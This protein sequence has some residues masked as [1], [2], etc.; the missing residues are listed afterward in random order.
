MNIFAL[1]S[2]LFTYLSSIGNTIFGGDA[3]GLVSAILTKGFP[4]PPGYPL[5]TM[6]GIIAN[7]LPVSLSPAGKITLI[8]L[9]ST[10]FSLILFTAIIKEIATPQYVHKIILSVA[11]YLIG[12]NY[13][14]W[15]YS[16]VPEVF[17]LNTAITLS[18]FYSA[19]K[20]HKTQRTEYLYFIFFLIGLGIAHHHTFVIVIPSIIYLLY[21]KRKKLHTT[22]KE[23][24]FMALAF[25]IGILPL[26]YLLYHRSEVVWGNTRTLA[27]FITVL[28]RA[29]YGSFTAGHFV[30]NLASHRILQVKNL[31]FFTRNDFTFWG[32]IIA[33]AGLIFYL[34]RKKSETKTLLA[35]V[36]INIF[37]FGPVFLFYANFPLA[38][39]IYFATVERYLIIY[40]FFFGMLLYFGFYWVYTLCNRYVINRLVDKTYFKK[41]LKICILIMIGLLPLQLF[42]KNTRFIY[43]L[44]NDRTAENFGTDILRV[45]EKNVLI[46]ASSDTVLFNTQ[47]IYHAYPRLRKNVIF[48]D[49]VKFKTNNDYQRII[50]DAYPRIRIASFDKDQTNFLLTMTSHLILPNIPV[51]DAIYSDITYPFKSPSDYTW[52]PYGV[53]YKLEKKSLAKDPKNIQYNEW[54]W[55]NSFSQRIINTLKKDNT[56][57]SHFFTQEI[58]SQYAGGHQRTGYYYLDLDQRLD[59]AKRHI[60]DAIFLEPKNSYNYLLLSNYYFRAKQCSA[61]EKTILDKTSLKS[62]DFNDKNRVL[63]LSQLDAIGNQ[64]YTD[65]KDQERIKKKLEELNKSVSQ[66][67]EGFQLDF[68]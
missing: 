29:Q 3:G 60:Q 18:L 28:T 42:M 41:S 61:A 2:I 4:H 65:K 46:F 26:L 6:L 37:L 57:L 39:D 31:L 32:L 10:F 16:I 30:S 25:C 17:P 48:I 35:A 27:N 23:K 54:F 56:A 5:Y 43:S 38:S 62:N 49:P 20:W 50:Q 64:C 67:L 66:P 45:P 13:L 24:I 47:Y 63:F 12:F 9:F 33:G 22:Y 59:L 11:T 44:K 15:L 21:S 14:I 7:I 68:H 19:I 53:M 52:I 8:S 1:L 34:T 40:Y 51:F 36:L 55:K 58:I